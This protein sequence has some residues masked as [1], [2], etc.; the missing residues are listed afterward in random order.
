MIVDASVAFKWIVAEND[1]ESAIAWI[2]RQPLQAPYLVYAEVGNALGKRI[3]RGELT[4][5][6][7]AG[8]RLGRLG[9]VLTIVDETPVMERALS[10]SVALNHSFYDCVYAALAERLDERLLTADAVFAAKL[11]VAKSGIVSLTLADSP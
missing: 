5:A 4:D 10:L 6:E 8:L 9:E 2:G 1:S 11:R 3:R 7:G